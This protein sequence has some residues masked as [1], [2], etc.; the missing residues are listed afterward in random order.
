MFDKT[1]YFR[2]V[3]KLINF[4][5]CVFFH[6]CFFFEIFESF[7]REARFSL[8]IHVFIWYRLNFVKIFRFFNIHIVSSISNKNKTKISKNFKFSINVLYFLFFFVHSINLF[9]TT[10]MFFSI[11]F[12]WKIVDANSLKIFSWKR[13]RS[14]F[15][16]NLCKTINEIFRRIRSITCFY[17]KW[18]NNL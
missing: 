9:N 13:L 18:H 15:S 7:C 1:Y 16:N 10:S 8:K 2:L 11:K 5:F 4:I 17:S 3:V 14:N 6:K 12:D